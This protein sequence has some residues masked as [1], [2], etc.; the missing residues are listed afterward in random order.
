MER[1]RYALSLVVLWLT[2]QQTFA[3]GDSQTAERAARGG[4]STLSPREGDYCLGRT[5]HP[6]KARNAVWNKGFGGRRLET[7]ESYLVNR[8]PVEPPLL[9]DV[10][11]SRC[12]DY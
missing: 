12:E 9:F 3:L 10:S 5:R 6:R 4:A 1:A 11:E 2:A 8:R 7:A